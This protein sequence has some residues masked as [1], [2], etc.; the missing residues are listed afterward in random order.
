M[1]DIDFFKSYND[2]YGHIQGDACLKRVAH[3]LNATANRARDSF[4]RYG[5]EEFAYILPE[6]DIVTAMNMAERC[7]QLVEKSKIP[8][9]DSPLGGVLTLSMGVGTITPSRNDDP[10]AFI[11]VVD[12]KLYE[13]KQN[14]RNRIV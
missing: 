11:N 9:A 7:S 14:G 10:I 4:A 1:I 8:H 13:A 5:G 2:H 12:R 3:I 6:T